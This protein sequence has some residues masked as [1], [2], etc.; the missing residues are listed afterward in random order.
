[1]YV[2]LCALS[3][4]RQEIKAAACVSHKFVT[5]SMIFFFLEGLKFDLVLNFL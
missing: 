4:R 3:L 2:N 1:M 5:T